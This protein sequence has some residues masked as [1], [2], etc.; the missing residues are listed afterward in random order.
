MVIQNPPDKTIW[1]A[2]C[3]E[4]K[5]RGQEEKKD[6]GRRIHVLCGFLAAV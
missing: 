5:K 1:R 3:K 6:A 4:V 2:L